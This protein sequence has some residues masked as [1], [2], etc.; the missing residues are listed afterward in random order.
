MSEMRL[1]W[2]SKRI[3]IR[4][5]DLVSAYR[6]IHTN[7]QI[8]STYIVIMVKNYFLCLRLP[9]FTTPAL[10]DY[11]TISEESIDLVNDILI[12]M[13]WDVSELQLPHRH[14]IPKQEYL[15]YPMPLVLVY[16]VSVYI[17]AHEFSTGRYIDN[18]IT[19][20]V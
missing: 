8:A 13:P 9:F 5:I 18:I 11:T 20:T 12:D 6:K 3:L 15:L 4:K 1:K 17:E 14:L 16:K 7:S 10:G 19:L 2:P